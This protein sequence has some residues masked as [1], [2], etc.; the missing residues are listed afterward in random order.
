VIKGG[1]VPSERA[2]HGKDCAKARF[3]L[4]KSINTGNVVHEAT[5]HDA[6][7]ASVELLMKHKPMELL[8]WPRQ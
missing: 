3:S 1:L 4:S 2:V 6:I 5:R 7:L 8:E